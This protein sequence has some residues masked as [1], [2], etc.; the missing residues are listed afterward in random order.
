MNA[1]IVPYGKSWLYFF[2]VATVGGGILSG[3][4]GFIIG[5]VLG[6]AG[7]M[8]PKIAIVTGAFGFLINIPISF[9]V[10]RWSVSTNIVAPLLGELSHIEALVTDHPATELIS[11]EQRSL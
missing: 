4:A 6:A 7:V 1:R 2:L 10:F 11:A 9:I 3:V 8:S 5:Y